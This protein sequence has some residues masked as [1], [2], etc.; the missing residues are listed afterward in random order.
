[1]SERVRVSKK[2]KI[3]I[4]ILAVLCLLVAVRLINGP[5]IK[6]VK[7]FKLEQNEKAIDVTWE[8]SPKAKNWVMFYDEDFLPKK[9]RIKGNSTKIPV[10]TVPKEYKVAVLSLDGFSLPRYTSQT[11]Y[12]QV[13]EQQIEVKNWRGARLS[14]DEFQ[15]NAS[16]KGKISYA[17]AD[18]SI[19]EVSKDGKVKCKKEGIVKILIK[20]RKGDY[21]SSAKRIMQLRVF[22]TSIKTPQV[23]AKDKDAHVV[24]SWKKIKY[25]DRYQLL[26]YN[27]ETESYKV[28]KEYDADKTY[29]KVPRESSAYRVVA[30]SKM[31]ERD[32]KSDESETIEI[33]SPAAAADSYKEIYTLKTFHASDFNEIAYVKPQGNAVMAQSFTYTGSKYIVSLVSRRNTEGK[34]VVYSNKGKREKTYEADIGHGNGST[35]NPATKKVYSVRA[36]KGGSSKLCTTFD[37]EKGFAEDSFDMPMAA[38]GIA[39]DVT[40][41]KYYLSGGSTLM[42][43]G[44]EFKKGKKIKK[45]RHETAQDIGGHDGVILVTVWEGRKNSHIDMY[46][47]S[48]SAYIGSYDVPIGEVESIAI[49]DK[50]LVLL[51]HNT[52]YG[53]KKGEHILM[54]K[55]ALALP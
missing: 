53:G 6:E 8:S 51:M 4:A 19:A 2:Q 3:V 5:Y 15:I 39:Y 9:M 1:M 45:K 35:Y 32:I 13:I 17:S 22:P 46:R 54:S 23:K 25:A 12:M 30:K 38:S 27:R 18:K 31:A 49:V 14:G 40:N 48:D 10:P 41:D 7:D 37:T 34:L 21:Y 44:P 28:S 52:E 26:K 50:H 33:N 55:K 36:H 29:A 43:T 11:I 42:V 47:A 20:A 16:A 24:I